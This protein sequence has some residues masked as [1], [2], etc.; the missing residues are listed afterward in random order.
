MPATARAAA[1][2]VLAA[3]AAGGPL[4]DYR[5]ERLEKAGRLLDYRRERLEKAGGDPHKVL[6]EDVDVR[7]AAAD[8]LLDV[9]ATQSDRVLS[10][11]GAGLVSLRWHRVRRFA[12][13]TSWVEGTVLIRL[14]ASVRRSTL[15]CAE[16][17]ADFLSG[18]FR[19]Y[20]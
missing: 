4:L 2:A 19:V 3:L 17:A 10:V 14:H 18:L 6:I 1:S 12:G 13:R 7:G 20:R 16:C 8:F 5:R 9:W 15:K 11:V